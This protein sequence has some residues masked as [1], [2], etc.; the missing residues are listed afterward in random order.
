MGLSR[1]DIVYLSLTRRP[2]TPAHPAEA[3]DVVDILWAHA[4][5]GDDLEHVSANAGPGRLDLLLYLRT[6]ETAP[7]PRSH[8]HR[9]GRLLA[10][11]HQASVLMR[12]RYLPAGPPAA[13]PDAGAS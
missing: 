2:G 11:C 5:P 10:R 3:A 12:E 6:R 1:L 4:R 8:L 7:G 13:R 9:A